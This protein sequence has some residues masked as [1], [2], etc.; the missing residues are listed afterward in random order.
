[1]IVVHIASAVKTVVGMRVI[2]GYDVTD[3]ALDGVD[4]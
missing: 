3:G 2:M 1:L 4:G